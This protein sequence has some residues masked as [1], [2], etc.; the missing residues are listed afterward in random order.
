MAGH[1]LAARL[2]AQ[3]GFSNRS[4]HLHREPGRRQRGLL[5]PFD[6]DADVVAQLPFAAERGVTARSVKCPRTRLPEG[7]GRTKRTRSKP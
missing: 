1:F 2:T 7:T 4:H 3:P 5:R 6:L